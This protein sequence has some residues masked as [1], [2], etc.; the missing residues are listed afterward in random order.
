MKTTSI[1]PLLLVLT[2][3]THCVCAQ[4]Y[5]AN[6]Q[7]S[8]PDCFSTPESVLF[9]STTHFIYVSNINGSPIAKDH[10]GFISRL[11]PDGT[12]DQLKWASGMHAP[13][14]MGIYGTSLFV[15]DIDHLL[16]IDLKTGKHKKAYP[17]DGALFLN[18]VCI[19]PKGVIYIS[20]YKNHQIYRFK[21]GHIESWLNRQELQG[22]NGLYFQNGNLYIGTAEAILQAHP[23]T[24]KIFHTAHHTGP[25]D[26]LVS[27]GH[28]GWIFSDW[29]GH[30]RYSDNKT[31]SELLDLTPIQA[32]A[33]D[34]DYI[35]QTQILLVPTFNHNRVMAWKLIKQKP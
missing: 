16:E 4:P 8:T 23:E 6:L 32:N 27:D 25:I 7:W 22:V 15:A 24:G 3:W 28:G 31:V 19:D 1:I 34:I 29:L 11:H 18:D 5:S 35:F 9:D 10:N 26:G 20:D 30:V 12:L 17:A 13:K 2:A 33:A 14:G 21:N